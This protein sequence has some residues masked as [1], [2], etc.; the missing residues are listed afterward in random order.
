MLFLKLCIEIG[1]LF[2]KWNP[3]GDQINGKPGV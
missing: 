1:A 3:I 2:S